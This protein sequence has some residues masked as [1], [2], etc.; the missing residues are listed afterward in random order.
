MKKDIIITLLIIML[1][2]VFVL[3]TDF[4]SVEEYYLE[5]AENVKPG[6]KTVTLSIRCDAILTSGKEIPPRLSSVIPSDGA[7]LAETEYVLR[8]GDTIFDI[9]VRAAKTHRLQMEYS[10]SRELGTAYVEGIGGIYEL[11]FGG[12]SGWTYLVNGETVQLSSSACALSEGDKIEWVYTLD[13]PAELAPGG[14][15]ND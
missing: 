14:A 12:L 8:E 2:A 13:I 3:V 5:N 9:L 11:D 4:K 10:G 7:V 15:K 6:D 1:I